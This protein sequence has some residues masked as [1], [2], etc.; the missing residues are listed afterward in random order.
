MCYPQ[1]EKSPQAVRSLWA[2]SLLLIANFVLEP[3]S[4]I[5]RLAFSS[6]DDL[7]LFY[8]NEP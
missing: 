7:N 5:T 6:F 3:S 4:L 8:F 1:K 2:L